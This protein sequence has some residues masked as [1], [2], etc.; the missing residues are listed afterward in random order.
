MEDLERIQIRARKLISGNINVYFSLSALLIALISERVQPICIVIFSLLSVYAVGRNYLK[1]VEIP[2]LFILPGILVIL[3]TIDG[4]TVIELWILRITD[5]SIEL[6]IST[7]QRTVATL[8]VLFYL[9]STTTMPEFVSALRKIRLPK[10]LAELM[11]LSY[12]TIQILYGELKRFETSAK[13]RLGYSN[14]RISL[15]TTSLLAKTLFIRAM[16]RVEKTSLAMELRGEEF[17]EVNTKSR[18]FL[19]SLLLISLM[20]LIACLK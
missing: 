4:K 19:L 14:F 9:I 3:F 15:L 11:F 10:F 18:G 8:S 1:I 5:K 17:P 6:A 20:V 13:I 12:R 16:E 2:F 7:A